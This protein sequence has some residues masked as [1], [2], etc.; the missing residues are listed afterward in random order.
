MSKIK[1]SKS[2]FHLH[3]GEKP[4]HI[5]SGVYTRDVYSKHGRVIATARGCG[6]DFA[7][8]HAELI[9]LCDRAPHECDD[10]ACPGMRNKRKLELLDE[11]M[12]I[13]KSMYILD[14]DD[15][16]CDKLTDVIIKYDSLV[17]KKGE[18][19]GYIK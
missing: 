16:S 1:H 18:N 8:G 10:P 5:G 19:D 13:V 17:E 7:N 11:V 14:V 6:E 4:L 3:A 12:D 9:K 2:P 15:N